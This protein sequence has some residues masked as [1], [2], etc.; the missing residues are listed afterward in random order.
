MTGGGDS[1]AVPGGEGATPQE[2]EKATAAAP[3]PQPKVKIHEKP[4]GSQR[5]GPM[6]DPSLPDDLTK[7]RRIDQQL[8][9]KLFRIGITHYRQ[10]AD[11]T[12]TDVRS[13]SAALRLGRSIYEQNW[14]EQAA[15]L[16]QQRPPS[17]PPKEQHV[18]A[19]RPVAAP[20]IHALVAGAA[21][22]IGGRELPQQ[23]EG[24]PTESTTPPLARETVV[25]SGE[26]LKGE[27]IGGEEL[28]HQMA[29]S[30]ASI[31]TSAQVPNAVFPKRAPV[32]SP[33]LV[34]EESQQPEPPPDATSATETPTAFSENGAALQPLPKADDLTLIDDLQPH[35]AERLN[36]LGVTR[37][38]EISAFDADDVAALSID[39]DLG[40]QIN[41]QNWLEQAAALAS[42]RMTKAANRKLRGEPDCLVPYPA[43]A[44]VPDSWILENLVPPPPATPPP[45]PVS[46]VSP[47]VLAN[48]VGPA[49][50]IDDEVTAPMFSEERQATSIDDEVARDNDDHKDDPS[51]VYIIEEEAEVT[52]APRP[53]SD[54]EA[55]SV[56]DSEEKTGITEGDAAISQPEVHK[57]EPIKAAEL[58]DVNAEDYA[59][60]HTNIEEAAVEI[61]SRQPRGRDLQQINAVDEPDE[62]VSRPKRGARRFLKAFRGK[63]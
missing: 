7:I 12:A 59:A 15:K 38:A 2:H 46:A 42:G 60:Y 58:E 13:L 25:T 55:D 43:Q 17:E 50:D 6:L 48:D 24:A 11:W 56:M 4:P 31:A 49:H 1:E 28:G 23:Q 41:R 30:V 36:D 45:L 20:D 57:T 34:P 16:A 14:I 33:T 8:A 61:V 40:N 44:L 3:V 22:A 26:R 27:C 5:S 9:E 18:V 32:P 21:A 29:A 52:I 19:E 10:I 39:C 51:T 37:F 47:Q 53:R 62:V 63:S 35:V 54:C